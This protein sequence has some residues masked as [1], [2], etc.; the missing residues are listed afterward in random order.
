MRFFGTWF[1]GG[2][3]SLGLVLGLDLKGVFQPRWSYDSM[4]TRA[5]GK[6]LQVFTNVNVLVCKDENLLHRFVS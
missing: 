2:L 5:Y 3:D 6:T 1:R 4:V